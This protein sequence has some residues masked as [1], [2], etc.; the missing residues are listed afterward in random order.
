MNDA[1]GKIKKIKNKILRA[2]ER[3]RSQVF[4]TGIVTLKNGDSI[5]FKRLAESM[6]VLTTTATWD[7]ADTATPLK[8]FE[9]GMKFLREKG[10]SGGTSINAVLG[11]KALQN[12]M[13]TKEIKEQAEWKNIKRMELNMPQFDNTSGLV[14]HGQL[15]TGDY[16]INL[17]TYNE[18]Y[19]DPVSK[20]TVSYIEENN[21]VMVAEDFKGKTAF[22]GVPAILGDNVSGQYVA[23]VE[24][25][26]YIRDVIDQVKMTWDFIISSAPL[27]IPVSIDRI[28]TIKTA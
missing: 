22:A 2:I 21:V 20:E 1:S 26:F 10:L 5:D 6:K 4:Q 16:L 27:A 7:N 19:T 11:S 17:W 18:T 23:P 25:E 28:Y 12:L 3:Q 9:T 24:G 13:A 15:A 14:Y 8:D